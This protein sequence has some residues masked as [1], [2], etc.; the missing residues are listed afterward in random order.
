MKSTLISFALIIFSTCLF[1]QDLIVKDDGKVGIGTSTPFAE[2]HVKNGDIRADG[3]LYFG[4][5]NTQNNGFVG[6]SENH[7][8]LANYNNSTIRFYTGENFFPIDGFL[9]SSLI[10]LSMQ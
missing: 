2:L 7:L 1:A 4:T 6:F 8:Q 10:C 3:Y 5:D 9:T